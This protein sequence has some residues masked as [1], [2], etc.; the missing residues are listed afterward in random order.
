MKNVLLFVHDDSGQTTR[1]EAALDLVRALDGHLTCLD[2]TMIPLLVDD[3][4]GMAA[5]AMMLADERERGRANRQVLE[6]D[7][8]HEG[9][10]YNWIEA[11]GDPAECLRSAAGLADLVVVSRTIGSHGYP[12]FGEIAADVIVESRK[13]VVAVPTSGHGFRAHGRATVAW[14]GS[15]EAEAAL[16]A[17]VPL[18][19]LAEHVAIV[20][21]DDGSVKQP[22]EEAAAYLSR[23]GIAPRIDRV[24]TPRAGVA[25]V[26]LDRVSSDAAAYLVMGGFGHSRMIEALFGGVSQRLLTESPVP[27]VMVH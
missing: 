9:I 17:T 19:Q 21:V 15:R 18:L 8:G 4:S 16:R 7:L 12:A 27:L 10:S 3:F 13:P 14:D 22:A 6:A 11:T 2:I 1:Y 23:H 20:E 26:L 25:Q 5:G 24:P